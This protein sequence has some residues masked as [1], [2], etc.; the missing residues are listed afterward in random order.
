MA[1]GQHF[2]LYTPLLDWTE[3]PWV[4]VFFAVTSIEKSK[5]GKR[6][7]WALSAESI[8]DNNLFYQ[9]STTKVNQ[10]MI[11]ELVIPNSDENN[12]LVN[13]RGLFTKIQTDN[14]IEN[15]VKNADFLDDS[16]TLF[17]IIFPDT[18][19]AKIIT[20]LNQMNINY[21]SLF[22]DL[23]GSSKFT[24]QR[25]LQSDILNELQQKD[26]NLEID[27]EE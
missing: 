18:L 9:L 12:R 20:Y 14:D 13:Q 24:N 25:L 23:Y 2:G 26:W 3:S 4:A 16:I 11:V 19:K 27:D 10:K 21:S 5:T 6:A 8:E 7:I 22:P 17:K 15:W 1:L